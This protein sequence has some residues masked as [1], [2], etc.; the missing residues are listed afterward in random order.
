MRLAKLQESSQLCNIEA[1]NDLA[2]D[3]RHWRR[4]IAEFFELRECCLIRS[5]VSIR[6]S[7]V[8]V[9]KKLFHLAAKHSPRLAKYNYLLG[10]RRSPSS[11]ATPRG[12][13]LRSL[14]GPE[15]APRGSKAGRFLHAL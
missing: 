13:A 5:N 11:T 15:R 12:T 4:H 1:N 10:H 14:D 9:G 7:D 3:H 8:V 2:I 6:E